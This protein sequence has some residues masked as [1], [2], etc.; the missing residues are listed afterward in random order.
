MYAPTLFTSS[1]GIS[2]VSLSSSSLLQKSFANYFESISIH[3]TSL[4]LM[5]ITVLG[6]H[7]LEPFSLKL[8]LYANSMVI[9][10]IGIFLS[11]LPLSELL[12]IPN[13]TSSPITSWNLKSSVRSC[14]LQNLLSEMN[15]KS[16]HTNDYSMFSI[17]LNL[18]RIFE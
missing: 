8:K 17:I 16:Y 6:M 3:K 10:I 12:I 4:V 14:I 7:F 5:A 18:I 2:V 9:S 15:V 11:S 1:A 13:N